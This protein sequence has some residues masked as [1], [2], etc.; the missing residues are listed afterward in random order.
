METEKEHSKLEHVEIAPLGDAMTSVA[1]EDEKPTSQSET[2]M[3]KTKWLA[4]IALCISYSTAYQQNAV[5]AAI[6][7]HID[8]EL[9]E[10]LFCCYD[11]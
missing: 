4:C 2:G 11:P 9:G 5:T 1:L 7:K 6:A 3:T 10:Y 8:D